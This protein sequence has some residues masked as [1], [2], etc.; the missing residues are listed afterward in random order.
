MS[1]TPPLRAAHALDVRLVGCRPRR[2]E[3][4]EPYSGGITSFPS[5][6]P[7]LK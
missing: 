1:E 5:E 4:Q 6:G 7:G 2:F 3:R